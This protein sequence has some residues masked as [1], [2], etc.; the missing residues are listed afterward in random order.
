V[1]S[2]TPAPPDIFATLSSTP[3]PRVQQPCFLADTVRYVHLFRS[4]Y[5]RVCSKRTK[6]LLGCCISNSR[7]TARSFVTY[8][9]RGF[10]GEK[11]QIR[12]TIDRV[13][14]R[15]FTYDLRRQEGEKEHEDMI[16]FQN[17]TEYLFVSSLNSKA[18]KWR[19]PAN[20]SLVL[21]QLR[22]FDCWFIKLPGNLQ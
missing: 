9:G 5:N 12:E 2:S 7:L 15:G 3:K 10:L 21:V 13:I 19:N 22:S 6:Q 1:S 20:N 16:L 11:N 18:V 14:R 4:L 17:K 8:R